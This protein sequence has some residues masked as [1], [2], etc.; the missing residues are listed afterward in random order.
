MPENH[1]PTVA[2]HLRHIQGR[3]DEP[4]RKVAL[5][6][7]TPADHLGAIRGEVVLDA[8]PDDTDTEDSTA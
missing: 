8:T 1:N 2:D 7:A 4:A 3:S 6:D 5:S